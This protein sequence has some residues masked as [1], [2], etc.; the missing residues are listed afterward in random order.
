[1]IFRQFRALRRGHNE[2]Q[3]ICE[4]AHGRV[5]HR[6]LSFFDSARKMIDGPY[7]FSTHVGKKPVV[8]FVLCWKTNIT[9]TSK[10][11][12]L[13][14]REEVVLANFLFNNSISVP[15]L[16][17]LTDRGTEYCGNPEHH[18]YELSL[19]VEDIDHI[20]T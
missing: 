3:Q 8:L 14:P 4:L 12:V 7:V 5:S 2:R 6:V 10:K 17:V 1:M 11:T 18:E 19:A 20:R 16:R 9:R 15:L 13:E